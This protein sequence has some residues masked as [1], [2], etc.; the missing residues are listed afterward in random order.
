MTPPPEHSRYRKCQ[1]AILTTTED[2][3]DTKV[4]RELD[5]LSHV[6]GG[7]LVDLDMERSKDGVRR[8]VL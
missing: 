3:K 4:G 8:F 5:G 6:R 2:G 7:L 1:R